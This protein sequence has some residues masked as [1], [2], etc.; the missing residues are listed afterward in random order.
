MFEVKGADVSDIFSQP[1]VAQDAALRSYDGTKLIPGWSSDLTRGDPLTEEPWDL[2]KCAARARVRTI[3]R[4]TAPSFVIGSPPCTMF[5]SLQNLSKGNR[6][7]ARFDKEMKS[8]KEHVKFCL[9]LYK[10]QMAAGRYFLHEQPNSAK[11]WGMQEVVDMVGLEDVDVVTCDMCAYGVKI[12]DKLGEA[13]VEKMTKLM[14]KSPEILKRVGMQC[15][16]RAA[17][18]EG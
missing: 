2:S 7:K 4:E 11:S 9:G 15:E 16:S 1:R 10:M 18:S 17:Q 12:V 13:L 14:S 8:A 3:V 5:P 6:N